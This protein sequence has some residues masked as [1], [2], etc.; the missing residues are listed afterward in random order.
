MS[1]LGCIGKRFR[2]R[3]LQD[4]LVESEV[5]A[6]GSVNGVMKGKH[7]RAVTMHKLMAKAMQQMRLKVYM[8]SL[9]EDE[10]ASVEHLMA[11]LKKAFPT[12]KFHDMMAGESTT[13]LRNH[14][15]VSTTLTGTDTPLTFG[16]HIL[17]W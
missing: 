13:R 6:T 5:L 16:A 10:A 4:L 8:E 12:S 9:P 7:N 1:Y 3:G 17:K 11:D 14:T 2:N 15:T